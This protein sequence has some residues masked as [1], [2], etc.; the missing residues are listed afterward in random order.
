MVYYIITVSETL[1]ITIS[2]PLYDQNIRNRISKLM[3]DK[4]PVRIKIY[5]MDMDTETNTPILTE[6]KE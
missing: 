1:N 4:S 2:G 6:V 5:S 3:L